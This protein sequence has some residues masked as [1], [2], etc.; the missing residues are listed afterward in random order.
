MAQSIRIKRRG[1]AALLHSISAK[2]IQG[3]IHGKL[4][5]AKEKV[6]AEKDA[7]N[8]SSNNRKAKA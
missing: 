2:Q 4:K 5:Q 7:T 1:L 8:N 6:D 3:D